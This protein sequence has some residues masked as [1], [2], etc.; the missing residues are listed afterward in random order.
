LA[1][2]E[3]HSTQDFVFLDM[4]AFP[5]ATPKVFLQNIK[6]ITEGTSSSRDARKLLRSPLAAPKPN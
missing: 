4:P 3:S 6:E 1:G 2:S 5:A